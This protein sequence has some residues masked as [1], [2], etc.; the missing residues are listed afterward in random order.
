MQMKTKNGSWKTWAKREIFSGHLKL[1]MVAASCTAEGR[2]FHGRGA[3]VENA[4]FQVTNLRHN[5]G[6][7]I[8]SRIFV[9]KLSDPT[10][11]YM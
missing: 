11:P 5:V 2:P 7:G 1:L 10:C 4:C 3:K 8:M 6:C 9:N